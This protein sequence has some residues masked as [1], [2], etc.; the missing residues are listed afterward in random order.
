M[1]TD[2]DVG[3]IQKRDLS[4]KKPLDVDKGFTESR[5]TA[6]IEKGGLTHVEDIT[7]T[8]LQLIDDLG[9][10]KGVLEELMKLHNN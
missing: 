1:S 5:T 2:L 7:S 6:L 8:E 10:V 3:P 9:K 4:L